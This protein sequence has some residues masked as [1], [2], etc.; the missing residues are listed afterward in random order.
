LLSRLSTNDFG[1]ILVGE[2]EPVWRSIEALNEVTMYGLD[3]PDLF[4]GSAPFLWPGL[5]VG[6]RIAVTLPE[7]CIR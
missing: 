7:I 5:T 4:R 2:P 6:T 3:L 1:L